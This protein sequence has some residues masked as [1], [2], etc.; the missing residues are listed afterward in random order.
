MLDIEFYAANERLVAYIGETL[1]DEWHY[2]DPEDPP[3]LTWF[4]TIDFCIPRE[5]R[6]DW[7]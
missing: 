7:P 4:C 1:D 5:F 3:I 2:I 6:P